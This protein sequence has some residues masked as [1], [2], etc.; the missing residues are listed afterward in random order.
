LIKC[1][2]RLFTAATRHKKPTIA[3]IDQQKNIFQELKHRLKE[4]QDIV[5]KISNQ[6]KTRQKEF[7]DRKVKASKLEVGDIVSVKTLAFDGRHK[8]EDKFGSETYQV[9]EQ[10]NMDNLFMK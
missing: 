4:T 3:T 9:I 10:P 2:G 1:T 7:Y 8:I 6:A 5:K